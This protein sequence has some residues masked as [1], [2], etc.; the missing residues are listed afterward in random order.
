[1]SRADENSAG[2]PCLGVLVLVVLKLQIVV[3]YFVILT[4]LLRPL[5]L[6][7]L[8]SLIRLVLLIFCVHTWNTPFSL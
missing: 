1:M 3:K 5:L 4:L 2:Q 7:G 6:P 8:L